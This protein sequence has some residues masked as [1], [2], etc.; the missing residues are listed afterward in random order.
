MLLL[1]LLLPLAVASSCSPQLSLALCIYGPWEA[2][3]CMALVVSAAK[4]GNSLLLPL[5]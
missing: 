5:S 3:L 1:P 2:L 4:G